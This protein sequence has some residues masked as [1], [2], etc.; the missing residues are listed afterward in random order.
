LIYPSVTSSASVFSNDGFSITATEPWFKVKV[1]L[2][3]SYLQSFV[4]NAASRTD[5]IIIVD[6]FAGSGLYSIGHQKEIFA[7]SCLA[8]L[9]TPLPIN[10]WILCE[11][12]PDQRKAL[13][14]R[15]GKYFK[16]KNVAV[17]DYDPEE[18]YRELRSFIPTSKSS[19]KVAVFCIVDP[20]SLDIPFSVLSKLASAGFSFLIPFTFGLNDRLNYRFYLKEQKD[21]LR[22]YAGGDISRLESTQSNLN[23]YKLL[24]RNFQNNMLV[25]GLN[26]T[27]SVHK[28]NSKLMDLPLF[29]MGYFSKQISPRLIQHDMRVEEQGQFELFQELKW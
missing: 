5:E 19:Y 14:A 23:F 12:N 10:K 27:L 28:L 7:A 26:N 21:K 20:F 15:I 16:D 18:F 29:Y 9:H 25:Q 13:K 24:V 8:S 2:I 3:Q 6:L 4:V 22:S 1:Q 17:L 11:Q